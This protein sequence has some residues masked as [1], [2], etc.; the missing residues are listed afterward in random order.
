[1]GC[2]RLPRSGVRH[3][4]R[5]TWFALQNPE[6]SGAKGSEMGKYRQRLLRFHVRVRETRT[7]LVPPRQ[8]SAKL[9]PNIVPND[10][11]RWPVDDED[12]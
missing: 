9:S 12:T 1:M 6:A 11:G 7:T 5:G 10:A 8:I 2:T 3:T 4:R